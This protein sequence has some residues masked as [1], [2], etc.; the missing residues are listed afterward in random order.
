MHHNECGPVL[1]TTEEVARDYLGITPKAV[2][3][4]RERGKLPGVV[5]IGR[6]VR[7]RRD[8]LLKFISEN[9]VPSPKELER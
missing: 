9:S 1:L 7:F 3:R 5:K 2:R 8:R 4:L 6:T